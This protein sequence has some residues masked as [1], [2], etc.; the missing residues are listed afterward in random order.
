MIIPS[1]AK[2]GGIVYKVVISETW[3]GRVKGEHDGECFYDQENGN[4]ICI[5]A[6]L[7]QEAQEITFIHE[8]LHAMNAT[9]D[10]EFLDSL[11]EQLYQFLSDNRLIS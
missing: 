7:S 4:T 10:H 3:P 5:G 2:I 6:E 1:S 11:A 9:M 8:A